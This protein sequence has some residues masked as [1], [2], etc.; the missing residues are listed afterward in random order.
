MIYN[1]LDAIKALNAAG[2]QLSD[3]GSEY[4]TCTRCNTNTQDYVV[5][6]AETAVPYAERATMKKR[7]REYTLCV[8]CWNICLNRMDSAL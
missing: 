4:T 1:P 8:T 5:F 2:I 6:Q 3:T 7:R